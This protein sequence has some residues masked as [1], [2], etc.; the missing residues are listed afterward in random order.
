[1]VI[2][3]AARAPSRVHEAAAWVI[4]DV[5]FPCPEVVM[6]HIRCR[7]VLALGVLLAF[8]ASAVAQ[9]PRPQTRFVS[10]ENIQGFSGFFNVGQGTVR[11]VSILSPSGPDCAARLDAIRSLLESIPSK[12]VRVYVVFIPQGEEDSQRSA[13]IRGAD[14]TDSRV[15]CFWDPS[16]VVRTALAPVLDPTAGKTPCLVFDTDAVLRD[17][18]D[19]P[20][21]WMSSASGKGDHAFDAATLRAA[22]IERLDAFEKR[23]NQTPSEGK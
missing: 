7:T 15:A 2:K 5:S 17:R 4:I 16:G 10:I 13:L 19:A 14:L 18:P 22:V 1:V 8:A 12:R 20:T 9:P 21:L 3:L 6:P 23:E 11:I